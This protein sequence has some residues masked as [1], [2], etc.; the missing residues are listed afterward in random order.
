MKVVWRYG[1]YH[2]SWIA[3]NAILDVASGRSIKF[4]FFLPKRSRWLET[5]TLFVSTKA[6]SYRVKV[7]KVDA[8]GQTASRE[9]SLLPKG[10]RV[11]ISAEPFENPDD[12]DDRRVLSVLVS[13]II[14][15]GT[16]LDPV[17]ANDMWRNL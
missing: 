13:E 15:D 17:I 5:K 3:P 7:D 8:G 4:L 1:A 2:D 12:L 16:K 9:I 14:V 11:Y 6:L 10:T